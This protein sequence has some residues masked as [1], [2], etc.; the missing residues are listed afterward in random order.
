M[1]MC[2]LRAHPPVALQH[3]G[4]MVRVQGLATCPEH[5]RQRAL[6]MMRE[7][8]RRMPGGEER[9]MEREKRKGDE[10]KEKRRMASCCRAVPPA[11]DSLHSG[12]RGR[13]CTERRERLSSP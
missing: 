6:G 13:R 4:H 7:R 9:E 8:T 1:T 12:E 11:V 10:E 2:D 3:V 5:R